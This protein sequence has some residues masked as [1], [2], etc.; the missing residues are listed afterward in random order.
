MIGFALVIALA[1]L[2]VW[3]VYLHRDQVGQTEEITAISSGFAP[4]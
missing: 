1:L 4:V 3:Q 2:L